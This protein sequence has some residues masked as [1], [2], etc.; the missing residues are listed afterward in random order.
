M[1][2]LTRRPLITLDEATILEPHKADRVTNRVRRISD[3]F[4]WRRFN[5]RQYNRDERKRYYKRLPQK[6]DPRHKQGIAKTSK[7]LA[8]PKRLGIRLRDR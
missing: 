1:D 3:R 2:R 8:P 4:A 6:N 7:R 5:R